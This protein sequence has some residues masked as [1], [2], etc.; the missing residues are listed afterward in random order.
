MKS[1]SSTEF[2]VFIGIA[3]I[4]L[5][6]YFAIAHSYLNLT[7]QQKDIISGQDLAKQIKNE[8]NLAAR[9]EDN[10][11]RT[12]ILPNKIGDKD[13]TLHTEGREVTITIGGG[14]TEFVELLF[15]DINTMDFDPGEIITLR[16]INGIITLNEAAA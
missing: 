3:V 9:V 16:R 14:E 15:T 1:Q 5:L 7:Y 10:Y 8:I 11:V 6:S 4:I 12:F 2:M 13:F